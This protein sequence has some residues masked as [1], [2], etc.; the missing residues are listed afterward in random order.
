M[1]IL[2]A[3]LMG[4]VQGIAEFF[5]ISGSGH[6]SVLQ[7]FFFREGIEGNHLFFD[8]LLPLSTLISLCIYYRKDI[9][10]MI[11]EFFEFINKMRHPKPEDDEPK[12][13]RRMVFM[14]LL[15]LLPLI[16]FLP[17]QIFLNRLYY[18]TLFIGVAFLANGVMLY[19]IDRNKTGNKNAGSITV[20]DSL[21]IGLSQAVATIPGISRS[22]S[23]ISAGMALNLD[24]SLAVKFSFLMA[25]PAIFVASLYYLVKS[26][27]DGIDL[28]LLPT[29][30]LGMIVAG[31][32]GY[33]SIE[34]VNRLAIKGKLGKIRYYCFAGGIITI[35]FTFIF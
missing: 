27:A 15:S 12:P 10:E 19:Y 25:V 24:R 1:N 5:P 18:N 14:I 22:G 17:L 6:H 29:Y 11:V 33:F 31:V 30:L 8:A 16:A 32:I 7:N 34:L 20:K 9:K 3:A 23:T 4:L 13:A 35:V 21:L 2:I 26:I 28:S